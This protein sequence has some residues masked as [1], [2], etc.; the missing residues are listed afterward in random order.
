MAQPPYG[1][2]YGQQGQQPG[3]AQQ[4][5]YPPQ[6]QPQP[7]PA[8]APKKKRSAVGCVIAL[9]VVPILG[10]GGWLVYQH[11]VAWGYVNAPDDVKAHVDR[12]SEELQKIA[13]KAAALCGTEDSGLKNPLKG[14]KVLD[15]KGFRAARIECRKGMWGAESTPF[16]PLDGV[17]DRFETTIHNQEGFKCMAPNFFG[18][19]DRTKSDCVMWKGSTVDYLV[20]R[21]KGGQVA[22]IRV[23]WSAEGAKKKS[24][25]TDDDD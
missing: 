11:F 2:G 25:K 21:A 19:D 8:P 3:Y 4:P 10:L 6:Q 15:S 5:S 16:E 24:K 13:E 12:A 20:K 23:E 9:L 7:A 22:E 14:A 17:E 18:L 1:G